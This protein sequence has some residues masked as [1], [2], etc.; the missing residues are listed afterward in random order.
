MGR[1]ETGKA[2]SKIGLCPVGRIIE[3]WCIELNRISDKSRFAGTNREVPSL[4][5]GLGLGHIFG[6]LIHEC[7]CTGRLTEWVAH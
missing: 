5:K 7:A 3:K 6:V 1:R 2:I 4:L